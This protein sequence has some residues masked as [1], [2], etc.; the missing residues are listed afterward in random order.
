MLA[1]KCDKKVIDLQNEKKRNKKIKIIVSVSLLLIIIVI[2]GLVFLINKV[3]IPN[4]K[5]NEAKGL[6]KEMHYSEAIEILK[7]LD[8]NSEAQE[9]M[10]AYSK[11]A[12]KQSISNTIE[13]AQKYASEILLI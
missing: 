12:E 4:S 11:E 5:L 2:V 1:S 7:D 13:K 3:L 10:A 6:A 8:N 9:L